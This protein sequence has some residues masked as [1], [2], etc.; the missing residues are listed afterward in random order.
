MPITK[1]SARA[2]SSSSPDSDSA[3]HSIDVSGR[4]NVRIKRDKGVVEIVREN[5]RG[6]TPV[7][8]GKL[9]NI[10][11]FKYDKA[12][13]SRASNNARTK[14][15]KRV[16]EV[17]GEN[18]KGEA[19]VNNLSGL[20]DIEDFTYDK[21]GA[22]GS[23]GTV[24]L[25]S[26]LP[27]DTKKDKGIPV[28][29]K[30]GPPENWEEVLDGIKKMRFTEDAP[31]DTMGCDR[32]AGNLL[33]PKERRFAIL[34]G[35]LLSSQTKDEVTHAAVQRL[36][37]KGLLSPDVIVKTEEASIASV[38]Y[39]V[40]FYLRKASYMKRV[41][42]ICLQKYEGDIPDSLDG[43]LSLPGVGPKMAH[44]VMIIGWN[45]IQGICVD[46]H[47]HRISNRLGWVS[48]AGTKEKTLT[49]EE[50]RVSLQRWLP[51]E[52]WAPINPLLV[53]F[54]QTVCTPLRPRCGMCGIS[55][56]CPSAFK[57][58]ASPAKRTKKLTKVK[59]RDTADS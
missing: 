20:P 13:V 39:P 34:V 6:D 53:G 35:S 46:T 43:L 21:A 9:P 14:R 31:V 50:T 2:L 19:A 25:T 55:N 23:S 1:L 7:K 27:A 28:R 3:K 36:I 52:E 8:K 57:E 22:S 42:E 49:P 17:V 47:V 10:E 40:G 4:A 29:T 18:L 11:D 16:L 32:V 33:P 5:M 24:K 48:R 30:V 58:T 59:D 38:I 26:T 41:A 44:L 37:K 51:K 56:L 15:A 54:G 12:G 45:N